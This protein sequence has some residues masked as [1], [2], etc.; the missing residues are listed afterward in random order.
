MQAKLFAWTDCSVAE[1]MLKLP[2]PP[3][4][5]VVRAGITQLKVRSTVIIIPIRKE[6][7]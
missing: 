2:F 7:F 1:F 5:A 4:F 3:P 6:F